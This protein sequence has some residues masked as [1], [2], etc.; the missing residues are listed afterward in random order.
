MQFE[1][2]KLRGVNTLRKPHQTSNKYLNEFLITAGQI[3][4]KIEYNDS[5]ISGRARL[6]RANPR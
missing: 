6:Q 2:K 5:N 1:N 3:F 4:Q